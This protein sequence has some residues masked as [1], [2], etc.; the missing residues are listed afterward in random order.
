MSLDNDDRLR[1]VELQFPLKE[2]VLRIPE[3]QLSLICLVNCQLEVIVSEVG[4]F[5]V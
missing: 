3:K 4:V 5:S 1:D 2:E